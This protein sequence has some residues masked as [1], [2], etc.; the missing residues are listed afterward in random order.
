MGEIFA[1]TSGKGGVGKSTFSVGI[2]ISL[3]HTN[4]NVLL[5]DM[6]SGLRCLD[7]MLGVSDKLV[8]DVSD[9]LNGTELSDA[10]LNVDSVKGLNLLAASYEN[11]IDCEKFNQFIQKSKELYD[12]IVLDFPAGIDLSN[13]KN[14]PPN[15][16]FITVCT[17]D[18]VSIRDAS[19]MANKISEFSANRR[20]VINK[21]SLKNIKKGKC[22]NIDEIID[23]SETR[24][25]GLVPYD[26]NMPHMSLKSKLKS[27]N[28]T[29]KAF[30]RIAGRLRGEN[31]SL[32][33]LKKI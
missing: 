23:S 5:I 26:K 10:I 11:N 4:A 9:V 1:V 17:P 31:I 27:H 2:S 29:Y 8:F 32:I 21:F 6:D 12:Y 13:Y 33:N 3:A 16:V 15:T 19:F 20:I 22:A 28:K 14:L 24:L 25:L 7:L 18:P 30:A